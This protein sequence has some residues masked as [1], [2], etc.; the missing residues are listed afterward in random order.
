MTT[1]CSLCH[2]PLDVAAPHAIVNHDY[3]HLPCADE[4]DSRDLGAIELPDDVSDGELAER[5]DLEALADYVE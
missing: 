1:S 5:D 4:Y 3:A 2:Q